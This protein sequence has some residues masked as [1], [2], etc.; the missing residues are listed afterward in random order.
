[1]TDADYAASVS[2]ATRLTSVNIGSSHD[3]EESDGGK[4][5]TATLKKGLKS[6][7]K[8]RAFAGRSPDSGTWRQPGLPV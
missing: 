3:E 1:M 7:V 8:F 6:R 4:L 2:V 5:Y